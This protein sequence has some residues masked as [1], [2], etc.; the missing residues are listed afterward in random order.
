[1]KIK[2]KGISGKR[3]QLVQRPGG[4]N[5]TWVVFKEQKG[6]RCDWSLVA[7]TDCGQD[8]AGWWKKAGDRLYTT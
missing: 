5:K 1:M 2:G 8:R 4:G 6:G 3:V 7:K